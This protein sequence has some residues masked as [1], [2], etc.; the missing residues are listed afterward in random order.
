MDPSLGRWP[1]IYD[2]EELAGQIR[3]LVASDSFHARFYDLRPREPGVFQGDIVALREGVPVIDRDGQASVVGEHSAW[4]VIGNTCDLAR[5]AS[6]VP[7]SQI[8]PVA[9]LGPEVPAEDLLAVKRYGVYKRFYVPPWT[10][11]DGDARYADLVR[12]VT[13]DKHALTTVARVE[14]RMSVYGW[15]MLHACLVRFFARDDGRHD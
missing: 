14:A 1:P 2:A 9:T 15:V 8:V 5:D 10:D 12:P 4:L 3:E 13:I 11:A 6:D 7:W